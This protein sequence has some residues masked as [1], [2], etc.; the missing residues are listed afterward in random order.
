MNKVLVKIQGVEYPMV[1]DKPTHEMIKVASYVDQE[2]TK[3]RESNSKLSTVMAGIVTAINITDQLFECDNYSSELAKENDELRRKVDQTDEGLKLE[4]KKLQ[5]QLE[6]RDKEISESKSQIEELNKTLE[7]KN[8]D[9]ETKEAELNNLS[10]STEDNE[11]EAE[12]YK[13]KIEEL[14]LLLKES[15]ERAIMAEKMSSEFQNQ[16]YKLQLKHAE[17]ESELKFLRPTI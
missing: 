14:E 15:E 17:L 8:E 12:K 3:V 9:I 7:A 11:S 6:N 10:V 4:I 16:A 13:S 2:M 5:F 1:G